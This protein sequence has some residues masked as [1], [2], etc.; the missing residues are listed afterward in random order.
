MSERERMKERKR[1]SVNF[2]LFSSLGTIPENLH[3]FHS[4]A[5]DTHSSKIVVKQGIK[6]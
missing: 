1:N 2:P 5:F 3:S 4:N 6:R